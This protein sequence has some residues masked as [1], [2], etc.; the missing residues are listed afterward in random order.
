MDGVTTVSGLEGGTNYFWVEL[1][2][3]RGNTAGPQPAGS[4]TTPTVWESY[5]SVMPDFFIPQVFAI[6][7]PTFEVTPENLIMVN[8]WE[9]HVG[10]TV[11]DPEVSVTNGVQS[12]DRLVNFG[13]SQGS[14]LWTITD[15]TRSES[16][17]FRVTWLRPLRTPGVEIRKNGVVVYSETE[18]GGSDEFPVENMITYRL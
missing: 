14:K 10:S 17:V 4:Y 7:S 8:G 18:N 1:I 6:S 12:E 9:Q 11:L 13:V 16:P 5:V 2:D 15:E 3:A